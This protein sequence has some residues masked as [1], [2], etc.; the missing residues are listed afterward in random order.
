MLGHSP[1]SV[2]MFL[3]CRHHRSGVGVVDPSGD[4]V[5]LESRWGGQDDEVGSFPPWLQGLVLMPL[6]QDPVSRLETVRL[7]GRG[8]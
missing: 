6:D 1:G 5:H 3:S 4:A 2:W 8:G 7:R